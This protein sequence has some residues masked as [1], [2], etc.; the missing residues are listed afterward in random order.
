MQQSGECDAI[1]RSVTT[2]GDP[3]G[4]AERRVDTA[5]TVP[6]QLHAAKLLRQVCQSLARGTS[7]EDDELAEPLSQPMDDYA[8]DRVGPLGV[9]AEDPLGVHFWRPFIDHV[10]P[11]YLDG[12][13]PLNGSVRAHLAASV[14]FVPQYVWLDCMVSFILFYFLF[15]LN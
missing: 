11:H 15:S 6:L 10:L 13:I 9:R 4:A 3:R 7:T 14:G 5:S 12:A 8:E 1:H 2:E